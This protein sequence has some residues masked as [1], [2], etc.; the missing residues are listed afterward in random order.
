MNIRQESTISILECSVQQLHSQ[1]SQQMLTALQKLLAEQNPGEVRILFSFPETDHFQLAGLESFLSSLQLCKNY[2]RAIA[3]CTNRPMLSWFFSAIQLQQLVPFFS[4][5]NTACESLL[6]MNPNSAPDAGIFNK[7]SV[8]VYAQHFFDPENGFGTQRLISPLLPIFCQQYQ[9]GA[10]LYAYLDSYQQLLHD[11]GFSE[12]QKAI[13]DFALIL[14]TSAQDADGLVFSV[15]GAW[16]AIFVPSLK[17]PATQLAKAILQKTRQAGSHSLSY[18]CTAAITYIDELKNNEPI[19]DAAEILQK[20]TANRLWYARSLGGNTICHNTPPQQLDI[21]DNETQLR[22]LIMDANEAYTHMLDRF[23]RTQGCEC[24]VLTSSIDAQEV[25]LSFQ[26]HAIIADVFL[27]GSNIFHLCEISKSD[28]QLASIPWIITA[29]QKTPHMISTAHY[30]G[31]FHFL[32][33]PVEPSELLGII[34]HVAT[35]QHE[36]MQ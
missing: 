13:D 36:G 4:D 33:H 10:L 5:E 14:H 18:S 25:M 35:K 12:A 11:H 22:V 32:K 16:W 9:K 3:V 34:R 1:N 21:R 27:P 7:D 29:E 19:Q 17:I 15:S 28:A 30:L 24:R 2:T 23:L 6:A 26:P 31:I 20:N 8:L